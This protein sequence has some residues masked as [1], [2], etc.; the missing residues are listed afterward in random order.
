MPTKD[1]GSYAASKAGLDHFARCVALEEASKG[2]RVNV[3]SPGLIVQESMVAI[4]G[5]QV[6]EEG[7][8]QTTN[9]TNFTCSKLLFLPLNVRSFAK[10][11]EMFADWQCMGRPGRLDEIAKVFAFV[12]SDENSFMTGSNV[13]ADGGFRL[14]K[15][16]QSKQGVI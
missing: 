5:N 15:G 8:D 4:S 3:V 16:P 10:T 2:I 7:W 9:I 13:S 1:W 11:S 14:G 6:N 12:V